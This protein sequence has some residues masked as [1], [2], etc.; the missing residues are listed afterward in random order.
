MSVSGFHHHLIAVTAMSPLQFQK[1]LRLQDARRL[2]LGDRLDAET[3]AYR[4]G[5]RKAARFNREY[6]SPFGLPPM[7]D[8]EQ[9]RG[10]TRDGISPAAE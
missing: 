9:L 4:V 2:M 7:R 8:I 10:T 3:A 5:Y 1:R 6:E